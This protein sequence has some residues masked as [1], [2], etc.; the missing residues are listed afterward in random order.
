MHKT[1]KTFEQKHE[2]AETRKKR[3]E[4]CSAVIRFY[5]Q[6]S[7]DKV[8]SIFCLLPS[9]MKKMSLKIAI[10]K[11]TKH[12]DEYKISIFTTKKQQKM[13]NLKQRIRSSHSELFKKKSIIL[14]CNNKAVKYLNLLNAFFLI[15]NFLIF[16][17]L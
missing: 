3:R 4:I 9:N 2:E 12:W 16:N 8:N 15:F 17:F 10:I 14:K 5:R 11:L 1:V 7:I 13:Q 6:V